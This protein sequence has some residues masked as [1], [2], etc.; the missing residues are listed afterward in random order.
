MSLDQ[1]A[2][3]IV[4]VVA[5]VY[6]GVMAFGIFA[7]GVPL[8]PFFILLAI[9]VYIMSRIVSDKLNNKEDKYYEDNIQE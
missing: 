3:A 9:G 6:V 1:I 8:W 5:G 4:I 7:S 2:L